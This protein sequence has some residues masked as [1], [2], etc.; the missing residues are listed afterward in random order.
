MT[1]VDRTALALLL[2]VIIGLLAL[3]LAAVST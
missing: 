3:I 2:G 1:P